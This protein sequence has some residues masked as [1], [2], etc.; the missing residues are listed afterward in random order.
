[1]KIKKIIYITVILLLVIVIS[2]VYNTFPRLELN[3]SKNIIMNY[4]ETYIEQGVILKNA[5]ESYINKIQIKNNVIPNKIGVYAVEY[6]LKLGNKKLYVKRNVKVVDKVKP[7]IILKEDKE[8]TIK[9]NENYID[10]GYIAYDEY[11]G[12][13][14]EKVEKNG[15]VNIDKVGEYVITYK[16]EDSSLNK[17]EVTRIVKVVEK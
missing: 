4:N 3:G 16:V 14:T 5:K 9:L 13:I 17:T 10:P 2:I 6:S 7:N 1:M 11:D 15:N 8:I 12:N